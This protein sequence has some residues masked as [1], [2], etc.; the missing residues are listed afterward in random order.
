LESAKEPEDPEHIT[1][2]EFPLS[3]EGVME[4]IIRNEA[5]DSIGQLETL[6]NNDANKQYKAMDAINEEDI[7]KF[8]E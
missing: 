8:N 5:S 3:I 1:Q 4:W 2:D 6:L 7:Q